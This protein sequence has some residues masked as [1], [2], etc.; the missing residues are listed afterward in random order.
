MLSVT[1]ATYK[2]N[3]K[4]QVRFNDDRVGMVDLKDFVL[5]GKIKPFK[6]L[7]NEDRFKR[8]VVDYTIRWDDELDIAPE[9]LYYEAFKDDN[10][11][12]DK[13]KEWGYI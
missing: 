3:Y 5:N 10:R 13:F 4:L 2:E 12:K 9:Y 6:K 1:D 7:K 8:F 11:L